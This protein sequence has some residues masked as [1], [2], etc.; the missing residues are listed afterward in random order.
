MSSFYYIVTCL[1]KAQVLFDT[2]PDDTV[3]KGASDPV[4]IEIK[5]RCRAQILRQQF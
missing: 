4:V 1:L 2:S 3:C 5:L